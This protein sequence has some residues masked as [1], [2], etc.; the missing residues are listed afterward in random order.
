VL[1]KCAELA[2]QYLR[3]ENDMKYF[4]SEYQRLKQEY[5]MRNPSQASVLTTS[6]Y[7]FGSLKNKPSE[8]DS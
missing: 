6:Y 7:Q 5:L 3:D 2:S 8:Q 4:A 1:A